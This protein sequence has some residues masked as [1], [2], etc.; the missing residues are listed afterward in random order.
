MRSP[1]PTL[2]VKGTCRQFTPNTQWIAYPVTNQV[3]RLLKS[4]SLVQL[5]NYFWT[6]NKRHKLYHH[7]GRDAIQMQINVKTF[8]VYKQLRTP[9]HVI[10]LVKLLLVCRV[11]LEECLHDRVAY[12]NSVVA[13]RQ[14]FTKYLGHEVRT[15]FYWFY[16][17]CKYI[18][19]KVTYKVLRW[20]NFP[21]TMYLGKW[22]PDNTVY[23]TL[24]HPNTYKCIQV[25]IITS[26]K[27]CQ[28][29]VKQNN[30]TR[31]LFLNTV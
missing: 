10:G 16:H 24:N 31:K 23:C 13:A 14:Q 21:S 22:N 30:K 28:Q 11:E 26:S 19:N 3:N 6:S 5:N 29:A 18:H 8:T 25:K 12:C 7:R 20:T 17:Q 1:A 2:R 27:L 9:H 4:N 15:S